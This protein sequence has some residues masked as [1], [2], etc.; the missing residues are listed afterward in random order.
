VSSLFVWFIFSSYDD[1]HR[2]HRTKAMSVNG[3]KVPWRRL[4]S[5]DQNPTAATNM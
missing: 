2:R 1:I 4:P 5:K 3:Q